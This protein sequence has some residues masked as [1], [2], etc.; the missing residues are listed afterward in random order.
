MIYGD[1]LLSCEIWLLQNEVSILNIYKPI[2]HLT[3]NIKL[4]KIS[5][6]SSEML[7]FSVT[8]HYN[9]TWVMASD[10]WQSGNVI[11]RK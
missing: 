5:L 3:L 9:L 10:F 2:G 6:P 4:K 7:R 8:I 1:I 11:A